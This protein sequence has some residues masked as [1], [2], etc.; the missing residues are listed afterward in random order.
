MS[1]TTPR[2]QLPY[3]IPPPAFRLPTTA[4]IGGV[5]LQVVDLQR[6]LSYY[7]Q[8]LGLH[9]H[10]AT[11]TSAVLSAHG[12]ERPLVTLHTRPGVAR[13]RRGAFGLYH[14]AILLPERS[15]L[16]R[17]AAHLASLGVRPGMAVTPQTQVPAGAVAVQTAQKPDSAVAVNAN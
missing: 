12:D 14:F 15:A 3:G 16:G 5:H 11:D 7:D 6:S 10:S 8:V 2:G 4:H 1:D 17:F 13:A 9:A